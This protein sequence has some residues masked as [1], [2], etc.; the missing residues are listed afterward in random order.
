MIPGKMYVVSGQV[1]MIPDIYFPFNK[2]DVDYADYRH[3]IV[4][5]VSSKP[6]IFLFMKHVYDNS[7]TLYALVLYKNKFYIMQ[8]EY[9]IGN[10][11]VPL[12]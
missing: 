1:P 8:N 10:Y 2:N 6:N 4:L 3:I 5:D 7:K 9:H 11:I 12:Q